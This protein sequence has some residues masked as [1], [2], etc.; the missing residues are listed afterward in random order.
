MHNSKLYSILEYFDKYEQNRL[1]KFL[2][3]PYFNRNEA[4]VRLFDL[5]V[6]NINSKTKPD[7]EKEDLWKKIYLNKDFDDVLFRKNGSDLLKLVESYLAQQVYEEN[8]IYKANFLIKAVGVKK[9]KELFNSSIRTARRLSRQ[10][11]FRTSEYYLGQ[12]QL[13]K[14]LFDL[15]EL[16]H[17]RQTKKNVEAI[18]NHLDRFY[19]AEKLRYGCSVNSQTSMI[20]HEYKLLFFDEIKKHI[21]NYYYE[22]I[23]PV[24]IYYKI[25]LTQTDTE[26]KQNYFDL[27]KLLEKY[28]DSFPK[29]EAEFIYQAALNYCVRQV[30]VGNNKFLV[31]YFNQYRTLL[32]KELLIKDG[33]LSP[34]HFKNIILA[35]LRLGKYDWTEE[36]I[37]NYQIWLPENM[38]KNAVS[39]NLAQLYFYQKNFNNVIQLLQTVEYEDLAYS[40][41]SKTF[42]LMTYYEID[43]IEPLYFLMESFRTYLYRHKDFAYNKR[44]RYTNL[45]KFTKQLTKIIPGDKKAIEKLKAE[46][47]KAEEKGIA[48]ITWLKEK[49]AELE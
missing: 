13:E 14:N 45:I 6:E 2:L 42:L 10:Q 12:Y 11:V 16:K 33:E 17:D 28:G 35:A 21:E 34:W 8:P 44:V 41:N 5:L 27:I 36:F 19:L 25:Y 15:M 32:N 24:A 48:S 39:F 20:S 7:L 18:L 1:R 37:N 31:E 38:R 23:P 29:E 49:I 43:E 22:D 26:K 9:M 47:A 3:S 30:N 46:V 4:L 40:L